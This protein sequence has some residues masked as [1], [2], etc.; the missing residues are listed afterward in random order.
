MPVVRICRHC[1]QHYT[2]QRC[3]CRPPKRG[4]DSVARK[5]QAEFRAALVSASDG[6]CSYT[7]ASGARCTET[8]VQAAH[9]NR[10]AE[11][12]NM[13]HGTLLCAAHHRLF[14]RSR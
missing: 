13:G 3:P 4:I 5:A 10:Y 1:R 12:G 6:R 14:D 9:G 7:D 8:D 11:D 2:G